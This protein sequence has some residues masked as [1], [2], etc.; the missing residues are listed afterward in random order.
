[1]DTT[2]DGAPLPYPAACSPQAWS[3]GA[4]LLLLRSALGLDPDVPAGT[5]RIRPA[6]GVGESLRVQGIR[7]GSQSGEIS[8]DVDGVVTSR[9]FPELVVLS[10]D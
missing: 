3:A 10:G 9:G 4:P 7:L 2:A 5:V 8:V 1:M 6:L